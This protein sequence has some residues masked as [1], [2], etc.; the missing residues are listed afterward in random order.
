[1]CIENGK[2]LNLIRLPLAVIMIAFL[3]IPEAI[4][5]FL[6]NQVLMIALPVLSLT[7][8]IVWLGLLRQ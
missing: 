1:M 4:L 2:C 8:F 6:L 3:T 5:Y 7:V